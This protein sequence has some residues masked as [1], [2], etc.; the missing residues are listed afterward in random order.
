MSKSRG[1]SS[2]VFTGLIIIFIGLLLLLSTTEFYDTSQIWKYV[3]S[4][5][6]L[7]G[8]Y[9]LIQNK[10]RNFSGAIFLIAIASVI[11]LIALDVIE[12]STLTNWWPL[13][14]VLIGL[15]VIFKRFRKTPVLGDNEVS[16]LAILGGSEARS[17]SKD[18]VGGDITAI[19]GGVSLD[20]RDVEIGNKPAKLDLLTILGGVDLRVPEGWSVRNNVSPILGGVED[21]RRASE[22]KKET[23]LV[24]GG[25]VLLGGI[26]IKD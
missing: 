1:F 26:T 7:L 2:Q 22:P 17:T 18:F 14:I 16:L 8:I 23:D 13:A 5:F 15:L 11:Q 25:T 19:L 21:K 24:I 4:V 9:S 3:P 12:A 10:F 20:I 6:I